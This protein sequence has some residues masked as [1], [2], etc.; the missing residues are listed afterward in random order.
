MGHSLVDDEAYD[1][2]PLKVLGRAFDEAWQDIGTFTDVTADNRR[3]E[4]ARI[5]LDLAKNGTRDV[6]EIKYLAV[7]ILR[8]MERPVCLNVDAPHDPPTP[9]RNRSV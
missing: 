7:E 1:P 3:T 6:D 4:L 8:H 9:G 5:I 2:D